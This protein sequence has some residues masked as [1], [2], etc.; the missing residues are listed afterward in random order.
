MLRWSLWSSDDQVYLIYA[1]QTDVTAIA[2]SKEHQTL[3]QDGVQTWFHDVLLEGSLWSH[4]WS[5]S[6][7]S[8]LYPTVSPAGSKLQIS[9]RCQPLEMHVEWTWSPIGKLTHRKKYEYEEFTR[10]SDD[11]G[12]HG[13]VQACV[14]GWGE[15]GKWVTVSLVCQGSVHGLTHHRVWCGIQLLW[16]IISFKRQKDGRKN[17]KELNSI[18]QWLNG[19]HSHIIIYRLGPCFTKYVINILNSH[20]SMANLLSANQMQRFQYLMSIIVTCH[21]QVFYES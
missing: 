5:N 4:S 11:Y 8:T 9:L 2:F 7:V 19:S 21:C 3:H 16:P 1:D 14:W 20:I 6:R 10:N 13:G 17:N 15:E 12:I 18:R